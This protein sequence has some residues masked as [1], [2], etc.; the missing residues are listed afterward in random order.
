MTGTKEKRTIELWQLLD[1]DM[2]GKSVKIQGASGGH[3]PG[4]SGLSLQPEIYGDSH[5]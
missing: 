1:Q 2:E 4:L 3:C 5:L